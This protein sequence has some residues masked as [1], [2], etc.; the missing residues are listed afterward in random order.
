MFHRDDLN[1]S[2]WIRTLMKC[3]GVRCPKISRSLDMLV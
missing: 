1:R 2:T 3:L